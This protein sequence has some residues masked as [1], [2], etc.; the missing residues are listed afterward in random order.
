[1]DRYLEKLQTQTN[2][3]TSSTPT[4]PLPPE[5][6]A[7]SPESQD[8]EFDELDYALHA[9]GYPHEH[10]DPLG[11]FRQY[12]E[13][14]VTEDYVLAQASS[15]LTN[16]E[17]MP[18][19]AGWETDTTLDIAKLVLMVLTQPGYI[20]RMYPVLK[21]LMGRNFPNMKWTLSVLITLA[22]FDMVKTLP[23]AQHLPGAKQ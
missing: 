18:R 23:N 6:N 8:S 15:I 21:I 20:D 14:T 11:K 4:S 1:V 10:L 13:Q 9:T 16:P 7:S 2:D 22:F 5:T 17:V 19:W 12:V 3:Q